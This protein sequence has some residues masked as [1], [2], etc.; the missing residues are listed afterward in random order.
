M[1]V[2]KRFKKFK[3]ELRNKNTYRKINLDDKKG[4]IYIGIIAVLIIS[5][6]ILS[7]GL[8]NLAIENERNNLDSIDSNQFNYIIQ[9]FK[10]NIPIVE[11]EALEEISKKVIDKKTPLSDSKV[12]LKKTCDEK[13]A[14]L[15]SKYLKNYNLKI[16]SEVN[17][18]ENTSEPFDI[19]IKTYIS[20][21]KPNDNFNTKP[22]EDY[23]KTYENIE[24][25]NI[26]VEGLKDPI[27][28]LY[29]SKES[30]FSYNDSVINYGN[31]LDKYLEN[32]GVENSS[33]YINATTPL[34]IKK[35]P[36]D[37][38]KHHGDG[39]TMKTCRDNGYFHESA[40]GACY[41]CRLEGKSGCGHYGFETFINPKATNETNIT[42]PCG[43]DHVIFGEDTYPGIECIYY[44]HDGLN[45]YLLLDKNGHRMKYGMNK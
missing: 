33:Y 37:P 30:S 25:N 27:P 44:S 10:R 29:C 11:K 39:Y 18:I 13:L 42:G 35:C 2:K 14:I 3:K 24:E 34:I 22:Y 26:N 40:D 4:N 36:Y 6:L 43:S 31:S 23:S 12:E 38:Y 8:L 17:S 15:S 5:F 20:S 16:K 28:F 1:I 32:K 21:V 7:I 45:E 41:L 9:D 19:K